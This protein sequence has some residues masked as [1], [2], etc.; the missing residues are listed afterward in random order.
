MKKI[1][2]P[3]ALNKEIFNTSGY[4]PLIIRREIWDQSQKIVLSAN[5][6]AFLH[7]LCVL[8]YFSCLST[9]ALNPLNH[10]NNHETAVLAY[11]SCSTLVSYLL[12]SDYLK[13]LSRSDTQCFKRGRHFEQASWK[14]S[15]RIILSHHERCS[16]FF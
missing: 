14:G 2:F 15:F 11:I 16:M 3:A 5:L 8:M 6:W 4:L 7:M 9:A 10:S 12:I 13:C 1:L